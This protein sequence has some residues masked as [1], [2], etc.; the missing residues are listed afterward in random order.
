MTPSSRPAHGRRLHPH[1]HAH[2]LSQHWYAYLHHPGARPPLRRPAAVLSQRHRGVSDGAVE[3][4]RALGR[5]E[6]GH[7]GGKDACDHLPEFM[8]SLVKLTAEHDLVLLADEA[9]QA[10]LRERTTHPPAPF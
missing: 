8:K 2:S 1:G 7:A 4:K 5:G 10:N 6:E 9:H 3:I